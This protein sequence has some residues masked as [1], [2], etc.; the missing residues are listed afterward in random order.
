[1][2]PSHDTGRERLYRALDID[3][4]ADKTSGWNVFSP[5][6]RDTSMFNGLNELLRQVEFL[7][8]LA[9]GTISK[10]LESDKTAKKKKK[11]RFVHNL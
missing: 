6:I 9:T 5:D 11:S 2:F 7:C 3:H 8:G 1:M 4:T 10:P